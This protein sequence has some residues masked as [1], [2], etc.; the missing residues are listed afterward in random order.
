M[1]KERE[2]IINCNSGDKAIHYPHIMYADL[3]TKR[4][5]IQSCKPNKNNSYTEITLIQRKK[6]L[7]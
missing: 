2:K 3:E 5:G 6:T 7:T 1:P 4:Y